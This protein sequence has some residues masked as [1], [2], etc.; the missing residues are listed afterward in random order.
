MIAGQ[1]LEFAKGSIIAFDKSYADYHWFGQATNQRV[2]SVT[3]LR[4][5]AVYKVIE[6]RPVSKSKG[7]LSDQ[8]I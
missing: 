5:K 3:R 4:S 7:I 1:R 8:I 2:S 6:H